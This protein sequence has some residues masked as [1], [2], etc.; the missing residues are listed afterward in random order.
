MDK[1]VLKTRLLELT[2]ADYEAAR[3]KYETLVA[4]ARVTGD[5]PLDHDQQSRAESNG[6]LAAAWD[7]AMHDDEARLRRLNEID[8]GAKEEVTAGAAVELDGRM[9]VVCV[10][11]PEFDLDGR[12]VMG[13]SPAAPIFRAMRGL[14]AGDSFEFN[15]TRHEITAVY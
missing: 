15:D 9:L 8:F 10:A 4:E 1:S 2:R 3:E 6:E 12:K 7:E 11:T 5:E 14:G 13:I